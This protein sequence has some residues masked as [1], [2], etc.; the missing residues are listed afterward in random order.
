MKKPLRRFTAHYKGR[1]MT[2][3]A[4]HDAAREGR[5]IFQSTVVDVADS[6]RLLVSGINSRKIG[7]RIV[8]GPWSGLPIY[9]LT[10]EERKTCPPHCAHWLSC[11]G[12]NMH[13]ARRHRHGPDLEKGLVHEV[14][15]LARRHKDGFAIRLHVLGDFYSEYYVSLWRTLLVAHRRLHLFGF[16][17][18]RKKSPIGALL[19]EMNRNFFDRCAIRFSGDAP[20][21]MGA[22]SLNGV[23]DGPTIAG[24]VVCPAQQ[25]R[26]DCCGT[27]GLCW[28]PAFRDRSIAFM[29]HGAA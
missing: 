28:S 1:G 29:P 19:R 15:I 8:K 14:G 25:D 24:A 21:P 9:T 17:A 18:H 5:S 16:T 11:Y 7:S 26:T 22:W 23:T 3:A 2:L 4:G 6:P 27:C 12:N 13:Y 20:E 10:L